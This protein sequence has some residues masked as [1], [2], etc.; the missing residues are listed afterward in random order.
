MFLL[1][2]F[3]VIFKLDRVVIQMKLFDR[4]NKLIYNY[5]RKK[6]VYEIVYFLIYLLFIALLSYSFIL[7]TIEDK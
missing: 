4:P 6:M 3:Q 1:L 5:L 7:T 2:M